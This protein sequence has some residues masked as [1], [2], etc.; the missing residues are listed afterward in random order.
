MFVFGEKAKNLFNL[1]PNSF[2]CTRQLFQPLGVHFHRY[3]GQYTGSS[4]TPNFLFQVLLRAGFHVAHSE[5]ITSRMFRLLDRFSFSM[6][7]LIILLTL[8]SMLAMALVLLKLMLPE[9]CYHISRL[10]ISG[11][12]RLIFVFLILGAMNY[13]SV[14]CLLSAFPILS[15]SIFKYLTVCFLL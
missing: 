9:R 3:Y 6:F 4:V 12:S 13:I 2:I 5:W 10:R 7:S 8:C 14:F 1:H 11:L 15:M